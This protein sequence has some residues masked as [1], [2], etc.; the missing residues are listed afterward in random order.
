MLNTLLILR[1]SS[2]PMQ[3]TI[4]ARR[5]AAL[6]TEPRLPLVQPTLGGPRL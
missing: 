2:F 6:T 1:T 5:T 4:A 3:G